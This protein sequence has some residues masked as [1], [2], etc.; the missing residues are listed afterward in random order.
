VKMASQAGGDHQTSPTRDASAETADDEKEIHR[1][2]SSMQ[3]IGVAISEAEIHNSQI[4]TMIGQKGQGVGVAMKSPISSKP[5]PKHILHHEHVVGTVST[6]MTLGPSPWRI[7][8]TDLGERQGPLQQRLD[9]EPQPISHLATRRPWPLL[10]NKSLRQL[11]AADT[12]DVAQGRAGQGSRPC[13]NQSRRYVPPRK[14]RKA[15][16]TCTGVRPQ[17]SAIC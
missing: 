8:Q 7:L 4:G 6:S 13:G 15:R 2:R 14:A 11:H 5:R 10:Q 1:S 12:G 3:R 16:C 9:D 17:Q